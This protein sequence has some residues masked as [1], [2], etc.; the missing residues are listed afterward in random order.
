MI[1]SSVIVHSAFPIIGYPSVETAEA[2]SVV[3]E[4]SSPASG[5]VSVSSALTRLNLLE[6]ISGTYTVTLLKSSSP[7][8]ASGVL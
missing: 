1:V 6:S 4:A 2:E 7:I 3:V 5:T 8:E